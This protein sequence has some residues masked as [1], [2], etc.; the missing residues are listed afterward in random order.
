MKSH[1]KELVHYF[2][3]IALLVILAIGV[4]YAKEP[5]N[6]YNMPTLEDVVYPLMD[7]GIEKEDRD[8]VKNIRIEG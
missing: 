3:S 8:L 5:I 7:K 6:K 1:T 4:S 2:G